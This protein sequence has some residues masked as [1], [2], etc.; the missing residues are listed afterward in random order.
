MEPG[1][2]SMLIDVSH[3][4]RTWLDIPYA[5]VSTA[6]RLDIYLKERARGA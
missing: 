4:R 3:V 5:A 2:E 1:F 6:Q